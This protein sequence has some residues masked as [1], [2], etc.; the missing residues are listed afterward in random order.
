[1]YNCFENNI[2]RPMKDCCVEYYCDN[3]YT[4][5]F[6]IIT[7]FVCGLIISPWSFGLIFLIYLIIFQE[8]LCYLFTRTNK[9]YYNIFIRTGVIYSYI[10][11]F[12]IGRTL[13]C[14]CILFD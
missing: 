9:I 4:P 8:I 10:L 2:L 12:I 11:G 13:S 1:M 7:S 6:Q 3:R 5:L 14:D